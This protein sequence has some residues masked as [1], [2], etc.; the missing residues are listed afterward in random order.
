VNPVV[1]V[2]CLCYNHESFVKEAL[3]SVVLQTYSPIEIILVDDASTDKSQERIRDFVKGHTEVK[4]IYNAQNLGNCK[5][6]NL[7]L[8]QA[9]GK[10]VIDFATDDVMML[11]RIE[12]QVDAFEKL[13]ETYGVIFTNAAIIGEKGEDLGSHFKGEKIPS[14]DVYKDILSTYFINP[15]TMMIRKSV[16]DK[17]GG[18]DENLSY[19]DFDFWIRS[20]R[21]F[22]YYYLDE[23]L[24][25]RRIVK[26]S[27]SKK[28]FTQGNEQIID[29]TF[30]AIKKAMWLNRNDEENDFIAKRIRYELRNSFYVGN[31]RFTEKYFELLRN[32]DANDL[33]SSFIRI[34]AQLRIPVYPLYKIYLKIKK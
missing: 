4:I 8:K 2:I 24:T 15:P 34:L 10:Y 18:Y 1:S 16:L 30:K 9:K 14:G 3:Q 29:S 5:S 31:F 17:L 12:R 22:K 11:N 13:D 27:H 28:F 19:E 32:L 23:I 25:K 26:N 7:A 21:D 33:L 20:S 6:F